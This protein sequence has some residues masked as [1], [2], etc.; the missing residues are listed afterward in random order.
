MVHHRDLT[1]LVLKAPGVP[2]RGALKLVLLHRTAEL[3][4]LLPHTAKLLHRLIANP[5]A[6]SQQED[7]N[8]VTCGEHTP[9]H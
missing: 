4:E 7:V 6:Q 8:T 2:T 3:L 9:A 5:K 1:L